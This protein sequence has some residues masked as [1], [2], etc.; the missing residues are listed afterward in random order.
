M[1]EQIGKNCYNLPK[2]H[3]NIEEVSGAINASS[4]SKFM[5]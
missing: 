2:L 5:K 3:P 4:F 1:I